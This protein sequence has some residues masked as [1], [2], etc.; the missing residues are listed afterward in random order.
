M[1]RKAFMEDIASASQKN[2]AGISDVV[3]GEEDGDV[4]FLYTPNGHV[5]PIKMRMVATGT[6]Y[7]SYIP[8]SLTDK[9]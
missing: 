5:E 2:I 8:L 3:R 1:P 9:L 4:E 6:F 7:I